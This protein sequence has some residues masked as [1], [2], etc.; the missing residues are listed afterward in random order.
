MAK[1]VLVAE[2]DSRA[3]LQ[4]A[5][6]ALNLDVLACSPK[7]AAA[8]VREADVVAVAAFPDDATASRFLTHLLTAHAAACPPVVCQVAEK[9]T[10]RDAALIAGAVDVVFDLEPGHFASR[11]AAAVGR[12][13]RAV[14]RTHLGV[15]LRAQSG[16]TALELKVADLDATGL[17]LA[18]TAGVSPR[19]LVRLQ[20][21]LPG[22]PLLVWG[23]VAQSEGVAGVRFLGLSAADR[24]R[25]AEATRA[26]AAPAPGPIHPGPPPAA[27]AVVPPPDVAGGNSSE[28]SAELVDAA[29]AGDAPAPAAE[30]SDQVPGSAVSEEISTEVEVAEDVEDDATA[31]PPPDEEGAVATVAAPSDEEHSRG[32]GEP[33]GDQKAGGLSSLIDDELSAGSEGDMLASILDSG[34]VRRWPE[35]SWDTDA[36]LEVLRS[37]ATVGLVSDVER[38]PSGETVVA[39][40]RTVTPMERRAFDAVPPPELP[41]SPLTTRCLALRLR[42]F[43]LVENARAQPSDGAGWV[44]DHVPLTTLKAEADLARTELQKLADALM[45]EGQ[46]VRLRDVN[47]F[48]NALH[49]AYTDVTLE[50]ARLRG[51]AVTRDRAVLLDVAEQDPDARPTVRPKAGK[52]VPKAEKSPTSRDFRKKTP[53]E[54]ARR[55]LVGWVV[56][57]VA[58]VA[59]R[60]VLWPEGVRTLEPGDLRAVPGVVEVKLP[61]PGGID[62]RPQAAAV[63]VI[64]TWRADDA[65]AM[66]KLK[67]FLRGKGAKR[68]AVFD[69]TGSL[70]A[71]G[72]TGPADRVVVTEI[73]AP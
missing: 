65:E 28:T 13:E 39:F 33:A 22:G 62:G 38:A 60:V 2:P 46:T 69:G 49:K 36:C 53:E 34:I 45:A 25:L 70:L 64:G 6:E 3:A 23:R 12:W 5:L 16:R 14:Q 73:P 40:L 21:P 26:K 8:R 55:R 10:A 31:S 59:L 43:A 1:V 41:P 56:V 7:E 32:E 54:R 35:E 48:A 61:P 30:A 68:F 37:G 50:A 29:P 47:N 18:S 44:I 52:A 15:T 57:L 63:T 11:V 17:G 51:E 24:E 4:T 58:A 66:E 42:C 19:Q 72:G 20:V 27:V 71:T 67:T 9:A